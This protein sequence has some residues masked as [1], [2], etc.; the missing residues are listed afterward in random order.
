MLIEAGAIGD[1]ISVLKRRGYQVIGPAL[2]DG[3]I[4]YDHLEK[5]EDLPAGWTADAD[6]GRYRVR[7]RDDAALFG[8]AVGPHSLKK[9]FH[10]ADIQVLAAHSDNGLFRIL[11][12]TERPP[13]CAFLGV[14]A[15][16]LAA[17]AVQ[18][19]VLLGD[20][21]VDAVYQ[22][23][24]RDAFIAAVNCAVAAATCFCASMGTG[25]AVRGGFDLA[26]TEILD[27][28]R[29]CFVVE[30]GSELG[31]G[32]LAELPHQE[33][34]EAD[35]SRAREVVERTTASLQRR[36]ETDGIKDLLYQSFEHP[37]WDQVATRCLACANCTMVCPTCFCVTV[38]DSSDV[39]SQVAERRRKWDSCFTL[40]FTYI[41]G[42]SVRQ[43]VKSR[44]RQWMT[45]KLAAWIDQFGT[46]GCVGCGRCIT[47]CPVGI[48]ITEEAAAFRRQGDGS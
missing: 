3:A 33:V 23:H 34:S 39:T 11:P 36:L 13:R 6:A 32:V 12:H 41:H 28:G 45:H 5:L 1:L 17:V 19:R 38:E 16:D 14:R 31:A 4:L 30:A 46:S 35:C 25:P 7:R 8:Y 40:G 2:R 43:S 48:D 44:Y 37:R 42:G 29:H 15:C 47:W 24:R 21:Y 10:P 20:R 22:N 9:F 27:A 26:L 18:D